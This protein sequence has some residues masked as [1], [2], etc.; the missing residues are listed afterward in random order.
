MMLHN[1]NIDEAGIKSYID[2]LLEWIIRIIACLE[3]DFWFMI[4]VILIL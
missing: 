3:F 1:V 4:F 2:K